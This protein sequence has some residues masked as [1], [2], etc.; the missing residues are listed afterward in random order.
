MAILFSASGGFAWRSFWRSP[1]VLMPLGLSLFIN[2]ITWLLPY[3]Q[4]GSD[5]N[6]LTIRYSIYVGTNWL[7]AEYFI[8]LPA[9]V[10][11][12]FIV[13]NIFVSYI[14]GRLNVFLRSIFL[15]QTVVICLA[16]GW[17]ELLLIVFN[18]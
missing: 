1:H 5:N 4:L 11:L 6:F 14:V 13:L 8:Y 3:W 16:F 9:L 12:L 7:G 17:L 15:W 18:G 2:L 10:C